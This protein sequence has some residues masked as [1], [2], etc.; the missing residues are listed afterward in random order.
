MVL[1]DFATSTSLSSDIHLY[2]QLFG[3]KDPTI[4]VFSPFGPP[5]IDPGFYVETALDVETVHSLAP[6]AT[7]DLVLVN[8]DFVTTPTAAL[9]VAL[10]GT[11]YAIDHNLGAVISQSFG[12][13]E[14]CAVGT[15]T[16]DR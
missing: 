10:S 4:N 14:T 7:I 6:S 15:F 8:E 11:K 1:I 13:G 9:T 16:R 12:L 3:L 2:D 5:S